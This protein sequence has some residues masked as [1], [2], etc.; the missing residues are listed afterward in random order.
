M[1]IIITEQHLQAIDE[2]L[3]VPKNIIATS[4][5]LY[6]KILDT[7]ARLQF[8]DFIEDIENKRIVGYQTTKPIDVNYDINEMHI[9]KINLILDLVHAN[10]QEPAIITAFGYQGNQDFGSDYKIR[11]K[12][13]PNEITL[14]I[15]FYINDEFDI[16][17][18]KYISYILNEL[19]TRK[20]NLIGSL[21][22]E[23]KH[24]YDLYKTPQQKV[25]KRT[26]YAA[27]SSIESTGVPEIN[28]FFYMM[29][30]CHKIES[31]VRATEVA[32]QM[33]K[34]KI[35]KKEFKGFLE[36]NDV[37]R[38]LKNY[39]AYTYSEF[40]NKLHSQMGA[41]DRVLSTLSNQQRLQGLSDAGKII[42]VLEL[43]YRYY[44]KKNIESVHGFMTQSKS[45]FILRNIIN[46]TGDQE[47][48]GKIEDSFKF[49]DKK[50][51]KF[52]QYGIAAINREANRLIRKISKLYA[53]IPD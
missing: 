10:I 53:L 12:T 50:P 30:F 25:T 51:D 5:D 21:A 43:A 33:Q 24:A 23:L 52:Y 2:E 31:T 16:R 26:S 8:N 17:A 29:Y 34:E 19:S 42:H 48:L 49:Y 46:P 7:I 6:P 45:D 3:G 35:T 38:K 40:I 44:K 37:Y 4:F 28:K 32:A 18:P 20:N 13:K 22:H 9:D 27:S 15:Q 36:K 41:I 47:F 39:S 11:P 14:F 1:K